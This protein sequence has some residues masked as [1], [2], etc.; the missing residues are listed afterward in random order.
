MRGARSNADVR[1]VISQFFPTVDWS[2]SA[3]GV[4]DSDDGLVEFNI[5]TDEPNAGFMMHIRASAKIVSVIV[6]MCRSQRWRA[7]DCSE[8]VFLER[9]LQPTVGLELDRL[10]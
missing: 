7:L 10:S 6:A 4:F 2:D 9:S 1:V 8:A 5:G 3:W